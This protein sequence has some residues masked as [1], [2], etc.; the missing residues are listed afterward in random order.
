LDG[1]IGY[2]PFEGPGALRKGGTSLSPWLEE[3][4]FPGNDEPTQARLEVDDELLKR[5]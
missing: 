2:Q 3:A 1:I 4:I 5:V